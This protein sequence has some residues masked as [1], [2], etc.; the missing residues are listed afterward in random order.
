MQNVDCSTNDCDP[1]PHL[2]DD[3]TI[4]APAEVDEMQGECDE[5]RRLIRE[6]ESWVERDTLAL[7]ELLP[8]ARLPP[9]ILVEIFMFNVRRHWNLG[10]TNYDWAYVTMVC[11]R[12][13]VIAIEYAPLWSYIV[14]T[15]RSRLKW[16]TCMLER[17]KDV[18]IK[19]K[20][21]SAV[22]FQDRSLATGGF[23]GSAC[24]AV[25]D[26]SRIRELA[27]SCSVFELRSVL[28]WLNTS[29]SAQTLETLVITNTKHSAAIRSLQLGQQQALA[30]FTPSGHYPH[31]R[32]LEIND[33]VPFKVVPVNCFLTHLILR[34]TELKAN[35]LL[36]LAGQ[37]PQLVHLELDNA[38]SLPTP[39]HYQ[40]HVHLGNLQSLL[41]RCRDATVYVDIMANLSFPSS[42]AL[43]LTCP[44]TPQL[45]KLSHFTSALGRNSSC[46]SR[47][48]QS[49]SID[50][51]SKSNVCFRGW[52]AVVKMNTV[53]GQQTLDV[54]PH[55]E[56]I[57]EF[58]GEEKSIAPSLVANV[59]NIL[60]LNNV[61]MLC[62]GDVEFTLDWS[63]RVFSRTATVHTLRVRGG[64]FEELLQALIT[65]RG[66]VLL[67]EL[68][69]LELDDVNFESVHY[70]LDIWDAFTDWQDCLMLRAERKVE[71]T[72][73]VLSRCLYVHARCVARLKELVADVVWDGME[74]YPEEQDF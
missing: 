33:A 70:S 13:R 17:S 35:D 16:I 74:C 4:C 50:C 20:V 66:D 53:F 65:E 31:L 47:S 24:R 61:Q 23:P 67:P 56:F 69:T 27:T 11:H 18:P 68:R 25:M 44:Y 54:P 40:D 12:W 30:N 42:T 51:S 71:I 29:G 64:S 10:K 46:L 41:I 32:R 58:C 3:G 38:V 5:L 55:I 26:R 22:L 15:G 28:R 72:K 19:L 6:L 34:S 36:A 39:A 7:N 73:M 14:L 37:T 2:A 21:A 1:G 57:L 49:F 62:V 63:W 45:E 8:I 9:E 59:C 43:S 52:N 60:Y 48:L